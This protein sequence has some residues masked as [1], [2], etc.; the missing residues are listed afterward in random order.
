ML[1]LLR[2]VEV[3]LL[4]TEGIARRWIILAGADEW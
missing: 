4:P 3:A 2:R 1:G